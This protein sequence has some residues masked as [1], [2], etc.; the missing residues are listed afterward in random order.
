MRTQNTAQLIRETIKA[1]PGIEHDALIA[2]ITS[3]ATDAIEIKK[4]ADMITYVIKTGGF[5]KCADYKVGTLEKV[6]IYYTNEDYLKRKQK[7]Q[8]QL[9]TNIPTLAQHHKAQMPEP[10]KAQPMNNNAAQEPIPQ[11]RLLLW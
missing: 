10:K 4:A 7:A 1:H 2:K 6:K 11:Q 5:T 8:A 9:S 3:N